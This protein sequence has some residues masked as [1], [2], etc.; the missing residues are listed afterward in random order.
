MSALHVEKSGNASGA[1]LVLSHALGCDSSMYR[2]VAAALGGEF[3]IICI[4]HLGHGKSPKPAG[5][6]AIEQLADALAQAIEGACAGGPVHLVGTSLGGM[7][8][9]AVA[10][11][12]PL[13]L[14]SVVIANSCMHYDES[15]RTMWRTRLQLV[16]K[17]GVESIADGALPRWFSS[18]FRAQQ[19][20]RVAEMRA[21]LAACDSEAYAASCAAIMNIDFRVSNT[22]VACPALV[23]AGAQD[24]ATPPAMSADMARALPH[25]RLA[26]LDAAHLSAVELPREFAALVAEFVRSV[27]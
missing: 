19:P 23:I 11:R 5:N 9:Q 12:H 24:E 13:L 3:E 17:N 7:V 4:D 16:R 25:A 10:V 27:E 15:A 18:N 14:Q 8:A 20:Q 26:S 22:Q 1:S 6:Y 21:V 2:E